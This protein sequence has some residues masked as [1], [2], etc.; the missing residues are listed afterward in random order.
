MASL[1]DIETIV[2]VMLE[3][4]SFDNVLGHLSHPAFGAR[5]DVEGLLDP[6]HTADYDNFFDNQAYKPFPSND[7]PFRHDLPHT[8]G[9]IAR[10]IEVIGGQATMAGFVQAYV[11]ETHHVVQKSPPMGFLRPNTVPISGYL[12]AEYLTCDR[13]FSPLPAGTHPN[14]AV[15]FTGTSL[16]DDNVTG[17]IP[18]DGLVFDWLDDRNVPWRVYHSGLSFFLL[19]G[20]VGEALGPNFRSIRRL[21]S[22]FQSET[23]PSA[24]KVIF[25]EPEYEDSPVHL[26]FAPNDNH[27]P[28]PMAPGEAF[29]RDVYSAL[30]TNDARWQK[31]LLV[32]NCD[33]HGGFYDH[34][35]PAPIR[36]EPPPG[37]RFS[38]PF[39]RTGVRVPALVA[40]PLVDRGAVCSA[41]LDHSSVLQLL[42]EKFGS[43]PRDYSDAVNLR[44][45]QGIA[46][47]SAVLSSGPIRPD[48]PSPPPAP[49]VMVG[50]VS[51]DVDAPLSENQQAFAAAARACV[52]SDPPAALE[53]FP[54]LAMLPQ[55]D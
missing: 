22:D 43:G 21:A 9:T 47:L 14:R 51:R 38:V 11:D 3:N 28:L 19:F 4:R 49:I 15:A 7:K 29:V 18:H 41:T 45:D 44:L 34:V 46:S 16:I 30:R 31:T 10:Q 13:W 39:E 20:A 5:S 12:A 50:S 27:P 32:V 2:V 17:P 8:R 37:A 42:G 1:A 48:R 23:G 36:H 40:S 26:G 35:P 53:R 54:E 25:I 6:E 24:P 33:E 55:P 52:D